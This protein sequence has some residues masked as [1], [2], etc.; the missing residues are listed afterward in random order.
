MNLP[1]VFPLFKDGRLDIVEIKAYGA[2]GEPHHWVRDRISIDAER[3]LKI[4][5]SVLLRGALKSVSI[6]GSFVA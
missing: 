3:N 4:D 2:P 1:I 6:A 5:R